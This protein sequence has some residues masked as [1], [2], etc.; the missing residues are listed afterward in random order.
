[1]NDQ[2]KYG[3]CPVCNGSGRVPCPYD[4]ETPW[5]RAMSGYDTVTHTSVCR[6]CGRVS[7]RLFVGPATGKVLIN[8]DGVQCTHEYVA[9]TKGYYYC[10]HCNDE[11]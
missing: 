7:G 8:K 1:M 11:I 2:V 3:T 4:K 10:K 6:N 5:L 9:R